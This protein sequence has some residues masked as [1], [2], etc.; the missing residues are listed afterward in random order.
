MNSKGSLTSLFSYPWDLQKHT[1]CF[2]SY[3]L[4]LYIEQCCRGHEALLYFGWRILL[5]QNMDGP[6]HL[7]PALA[8]VDN[9][10]SSLGLIAY[11]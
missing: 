2:K 7:Y 4:V 5:A 10:L 9:I 6:Y 1:I 3:S 8:F 11:P